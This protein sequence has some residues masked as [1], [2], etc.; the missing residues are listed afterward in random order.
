MK[1]PRIQQV[2]QGD[3]EEDVAAENRDAIS[4][5]GDKAKAIAGLATWERTR[6]P[7]EKSIAM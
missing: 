1:Q 5:K 3:S 2:A 6:L 4:S 7:I